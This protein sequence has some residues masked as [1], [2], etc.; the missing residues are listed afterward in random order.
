MA[1]WLEDA[2]ADP[3]ARAGVALCLADWPE[4]PV[5]G[6]ITAD[7]GYVRRHGATGKYEGAYDAAALRADATSVRR[8]RREDRDVY[9]YLNNDVSGHAVRDAAALA[10][11]VRRPRRGR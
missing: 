2:V 5:T 6:P 1:S 3:L 8:W 10:R 9:V 4:L 11:L 7:F